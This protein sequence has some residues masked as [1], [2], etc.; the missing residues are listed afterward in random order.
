MLRF[1]SGQGMPLTGE[2]E[3]QRR[4]EGVAEHSFI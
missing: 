4:K 1:A 3:A 2:K